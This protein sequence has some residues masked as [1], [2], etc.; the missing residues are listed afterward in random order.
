MKPSGTR[1]V[2]ITLAILLLAASASAGKIV[3]VN[4]AGSGVFTFDQPAV[5]SSGTIAHVVFIG[6]A[7]GDNTFKLYYA[8]VDKSANFKDAGATQAD[9][10]LTAAVAIDN[11]SKYRDVRHPQIAVR[12]TRRAGGAFPGRPDRLR[13]RGIQ[14]VP[15]AHRP[16]QQH[17]DV[18]DRGRDPRFRLHRARREPRRSGLPGGDLRQHPAHRLRGL[19][20]RVQQCVLHKGRDRQR[21]RRGRPHPAFRATTPAGGSSPFPG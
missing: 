20:D 10:L 17:R 7:A 2:P 5:V 6:D 21:G 16:P 14:A 13:H 15:G 8:A 9:I 3:P 4:G 18:A 12:K 11:G 19:V 1:V